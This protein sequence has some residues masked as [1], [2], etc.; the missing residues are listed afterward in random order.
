MYKINEI[1]KLTGLS[2]STLL[3]Y[4]RIELVVPEKELN[5]D[6]R[7]YSEVDLKDL[8]KVCMY[9]DMGLP[10]IEIKDIIHGI[11]TNIK[12][13]LEKQLEK[14][15]SQIQLLREQQKRILDII[16]VDDL[17]LNTRYMDKET[18]IKIL[19]RSGL[20]KDGMIKW[21]IAFERNA[22]E[23]HQ[24]FLESINIPKDQI[25]QIRK[26]SLS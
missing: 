17:S 12:G 11:N 26:W 18:W 1:T 9:R 16:R 8:K 3:Y 20:D 23:A 2:R 22:P 15:N 24:D 5:N 25:K 19:K 21:H 4:E 6:Y 13:I 7:L 14:I 10:L